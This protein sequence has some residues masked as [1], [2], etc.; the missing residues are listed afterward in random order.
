MEIVDTFCHIG[1]TVKLGA[2]CKH[3]TTARAMS[4]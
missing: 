4:I 1:N 3:G 2:G